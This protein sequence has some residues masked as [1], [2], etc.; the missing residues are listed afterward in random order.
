MGKRTC[1]FFG[2]RK[3]SDA[4]NLREKI[5]EVVENLIVK[6]NT[7]I[8]LFG[9]R[10]EFNSLCHSV[11]TELKKK[12]SQ[13]SRI[14]VRAEYPYI[15][16]DYKSYLLKGYEDT[17]FPKKAINSGKAVYIERNFEMIDRSDI[18]VVYYKEDYI[19]KS[20]KIRIQKAEQKLHTNMRKKEVSIL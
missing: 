13:I 17:Y 5:Y 8:F 2:H 18:C 9:S 20:T 11:V 7:E 16:E 1:C 6:N 12:Y 15:D 4:E 19:P 3:I 10:S 14:Y